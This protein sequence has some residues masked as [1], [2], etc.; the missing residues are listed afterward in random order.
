MACTESLDTNL[1]MQAIVEPQDIA[2]F[3]ENKY[4]DCGRMLNVL[5]NYSTLQHIEQFYCMTTEGWTGM[6]L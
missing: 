1:T 4:A 2:N 6:V 3:I 5:A